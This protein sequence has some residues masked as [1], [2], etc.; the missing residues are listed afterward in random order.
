MTEQV[1]KDI[2]LITG[3][4]GAEKMFGKKKK[5]VPVPDE[6]RGLKIKTQSSICT[7]ETIIG[8]YDANTR[9]LLCAE[10]VRNQSDIDNY[11]KK[12]G[13]EESYENI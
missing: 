6:C 8:F 10:L 3:K 5:V 11:N 7:G 2:I 4:K 13:M 1:L 9:K 12:Y